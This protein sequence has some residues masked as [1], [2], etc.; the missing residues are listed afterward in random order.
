[1]RHSALP[2]AL[3]LTVLGVFLAAVPMAA[4]GTGIGS[5]AGI[6]GTV[7]A[8]YYTTDP[9]RDEAGIPLPGD[10]DRASCTVD[11][12]VMDEIAAAYSTLPNLISVVPYDPHEPNPPSTPIG[13]HA[14]IFALADCMP[15]VTV[16]LRSHYPDAKVL[17]DV[18]PLFYDNRDGSGVNL[19]LFYQ[20]RAAAFFRIVSSGE[21]F[22]PEELLGLVV[23]QEAHD[24][25]NLHVNRAIEHGPA[26]WTAG[27]DWSG[28]DTVAGFVAH[29]AF[30]PRQND[31][32]PWRLDVP[33]IYDYGTFNPNRPDDPLNSG[34]FPA[35]HATWVE[36]LRPDQ[37]P[38]LNIRGFIAL[39]R[40]YA[41][42][43]T[44]GAV[45][46]SQLA[47]CRWASTQQE[48]DI[49]W[50]VV[51]TRRA[52]FDGQSEL[53]GLDYLDRFGHPDQN[54][55]TEE[56]FELARGSTGGCGI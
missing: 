44:D 11:V 45:R 38:A 32:F 49:A 50:T 6:F 27:N 35:A 17:L 34:A 53:L 47:W 52:M 37:R 4:A 7:V 12:S 42:G 56:F 1:M 23:R 26:S 24:L 30:F 13:E 16:W 20:Q 51:W 18:S 31:S 9:D 43:W 36:H 29:P 33:V 10:P 8:V 39:P 54:A 2:A 41:N 22:L 19:D 46:W 15:D 14:D 48:L 55:Q 40:D 5:H 28:V 3:G 25:P 21:H